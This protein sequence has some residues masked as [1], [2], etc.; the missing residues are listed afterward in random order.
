M[1]V[2]AVVVFLALFVALSGTNIFIENINPDELS[3]MGIERKS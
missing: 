3:S 1:L 2:I